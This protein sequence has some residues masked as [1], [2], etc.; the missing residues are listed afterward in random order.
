MSTPTFYQPELSEGD[1]TASLSSQES[2]HAYK[3]RRLRVGSTIRLIN[4]LGLSAD[5]QIDS[6][7]SNRLTV[8]VS[9]IKQHPKPLRQCC[10]AAAIPKGDRQRF[11]VEMLTQLGVTEII[12]L[13]CDYSATG[14]KQTSYEKWQRYAV[15]ACKQSQNTWLPQIQAGCSLE[16][17]LNQKKSTRDEIVYADSAGH[18]SE[19][20]LQSNKGITICIG[21][22][23]GFSQKEFEMFARAE[24]HAVQLGEHILRTETAAV[25]AATLLLLR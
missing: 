23:G 25:V 5:A 14:Y 24:A 11:M 21:P 3:S 10:I 12:P 6:T 19:S 20:F 18:S 15:E 17:L 16:F 7:D 2:A 8:Q 13:Q 1:A 9:N 4:G 22:E